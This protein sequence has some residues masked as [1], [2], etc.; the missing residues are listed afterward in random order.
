MAITT[1]TVKRFA[2]QCVAV[3]FVMYALAD[4]SVLQ[5][6]CGNESVGIPPSHHLAKSTA[7]SE[8][9]KS[10]VKED[11]SYFNHCTEGEQD[12]PED[13]NDDCCF[14]C[15][16]HVTISYFAMQP[17]ETVVLPLAQDSSS[18]ENKHPNSGLAYLFRP[19]RI[20]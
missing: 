18:F 6:Y 7:D 20:A 19:P 2:T 1:K 13:C 10:S 4:I 9:S 17:T 16:S 5:A 3:L 8:S 12:S 15:S 11:Q 14:C